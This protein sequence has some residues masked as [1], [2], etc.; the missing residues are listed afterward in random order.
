M[1]VFLEDNPT[2]TIIV[3]FRYE[4]DTD[5]RPY[6]S[7]KLF[8]STFQK[9][10][11]SFTGMLASNSTT[12]RSGIGSVRGRAVFL[13]DPTLNLGNLTSDPIVFWGPGFVDEDHYQLTV[14]DQKWTYLT[15]N[16]NQAM[17]DNTSNVAYAS[18]V[19]MSNFDP[20]PGKEIDPIMFANWVQPKMRTFLAPVGQTRLGVVAMDFYAEDIVKTIIQTNKGVKL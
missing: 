17:A 4:N 5:T 9:E 19:A 10:I 14:Y 13:A 8:A 3:T 6:S 16:W 2:E 20:L 1:K 11:Q 18:V 7:P 12:M 15:Q